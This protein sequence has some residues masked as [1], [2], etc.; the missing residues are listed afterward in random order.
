MYQSKWP[1]YTDEMKQNVFNIL[2][3]GKVNQWTGSKVFEFEKKFSQYFGVEHSIAVFNGSVALELCLKT[4]E[5][6]IGDEVIVTPRTFIASASSISLLGATPIFVDVDHSQNITLEN[7]IKA[8]TNKTKAVI[9]VHLAGWPC[10][11]EEI[12]SWCH[13]NNIYVIEDCAQAHGAKYKNKFVGTWGDINA[14]SF[15]QDKIISTGGEGGMV[16]TNNKNLYLKAWSYKDHGKNMEKIFSNKSE[17]GMF[18]WVHD[19]IGTNLRMTEIQASIGI[20]SLNYLDDW[21]T[22]RRRN[23]FIF[24]ENLKNLNLVYIPT[25]NEKYFHVYYKYYIF[26][27]KEYLREEYSVK[28]IIIDINNNGIPCFQGTCGEVYKEKAFNLN[29]DLPVTKNLTERSIMFL[30]D[31][32]FGEEIMQ[33]IASKVKQILLKY[34]IE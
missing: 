6:G 11:L 2:S 32:S 21:V 25:P 28:D 23:A 14:W 5:I 30:V 31:P 26:I 1:Y 20:D 7:I 13:E 27:N 34:Q 17:P 19:S 29:I 24:S 33:E 22:S 3:S 12:V 4:L 15:C 9:L 18:K 8:K 10:D 16:T